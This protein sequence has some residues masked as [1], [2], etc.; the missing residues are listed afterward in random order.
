MNKRIVLGI[1]LIL[2]GLG[3]T[4]L[5]LASF[6][7]FTASVNDDC[8]NKKIYFS[9][10]K[11]D[12]RIQCP[13]FLYLN[14]GDSNIVILS[15]YALILIQCVLQGVIFIDYTIRTIF[16]K[17]E[18]VQF[19]YYLEKIKKDGMDA[20]LEDRIIIYIIHIIIPAFL[21]S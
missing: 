11:T 5:I 8:G 12:Q 3:S 21:S 7:T 10:A 17:L 19:Y 2:S 4:F 13:K 14:D 16:I 20:Q 15:M 18:K 6:N 1:L 9:Y